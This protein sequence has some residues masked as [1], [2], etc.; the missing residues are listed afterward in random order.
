VRHQLFIITQTGC[1]PAL[2][3]TPPTEK[4]AELERLEEIVHALKPGLGR[5]YL[6]ATVRCDEHGIVFEEDAR[7][8]RGESEVLASN[9][10]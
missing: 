10:V 2:T 9:C 5:H 6:T 1:Y 8:L 3:G 4:V 7:F